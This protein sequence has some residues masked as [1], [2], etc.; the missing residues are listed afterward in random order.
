M[1]ESDNK[2]P[3][4]WSKVDGLIRKDEQSLAPAALPKDNPLALAVAWVQAHRDLPK[5]LRSKS[6]T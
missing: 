6:L 2:I 3:S 5:S 4:D 1:T